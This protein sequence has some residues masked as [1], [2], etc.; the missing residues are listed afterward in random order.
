M[1]SHPTKRDT[2]KMNKLLKTNLLIWTM[3][4]V[5]I[6]L[7]GDTVNTAILSSL[8]GNGQIITVILNVI[9]AALALGRLAYRFKMINRFDLAMAL[10][11]LVTCIN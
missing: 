1:L 2:A 3:A 9:G 10:P 4:A 8:F 11:A 6:A 5:L 7:C